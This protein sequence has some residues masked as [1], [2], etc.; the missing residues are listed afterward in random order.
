M[1]DWQLESLR[2]GMEKKRV[3][4]WILVVLLLSR[5]LLAADVIIAALQAT[6]IKRKK[7][8]LVQRTIILKNKEPLGF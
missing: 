3:V 5:S 8:S 2:D 4:M 7:C 6:E 1:K